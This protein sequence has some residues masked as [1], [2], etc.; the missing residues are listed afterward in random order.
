MHEDRIEVKSGLKLK[1]IRLP[2]NMDYL[3]FHDLYYINNKLFAIVA[4]NKPYD[5]RYEIDEEK[6]EL[7]G[8]PIPTY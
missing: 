3:Q 5:V 7:T 4:T 6:I 1:E 2:Y 8:E